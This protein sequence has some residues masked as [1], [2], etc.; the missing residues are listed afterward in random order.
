MVLTAL[1]AARDHRGAAWCIADGPMDH[2]GGRDNSF[3]LRFHEARPDNLS[4]NAT[5]DAVQDDLESS[6]IEHGWW[7]MTSRPASQ[8][9][10]DNFPPSERSERSTYGNESVTATMVPTKKYRRSRRRQ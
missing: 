9:I 3:A 8:A 2:L 6:G 4:I 7:P 10:S 5:C 1:N